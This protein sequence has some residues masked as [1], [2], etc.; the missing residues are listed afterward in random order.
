MSVPVQKLLA[1]QQ[2]IESGKLDQ[3]KA[4]LLRLAQGGGAQDRNL[5]NMLA[6]VLGKKGEYEQA[7]Y[8]LERALKA[9]PDDGFLLTNL[10]QLL[11]ETGKRAEAVEVLERAI[12][13]AP[14][15]DGAWVNLTSTL[16]AMRRYATAR[17]KAAEALE[18]FNGHARL[19]RNLSVAL[20]GAGE[21]QAAHEAARE[22]AT[23]EPSNPAA[24][25]MLAY[26]YN[27]VPGPTPA[28]ILAAHRA[29]G[30]CLQRLRPSPQAPAPTAADAERPLRVGMIGGDFCTHSV[31]FFVEPLLEHRD[32][33]AWHVTLY[34][35][36]TNTDATSERF[37]SLA[38]AWRHVAWMNERELIGQIQHDRIDVLID[39]AGHTANN[40][41]PILHLRAA[42]MQMTYCG[43]PATTGVAA[44]DYRIVDSLTDPGPQADAA[45]VEKLAR[46]DPCFLCYRPVQ[47]PSG[48][49]VPAPSPPPSASGA[50]VTFGSFN[51]LSKL[52]DRLIGV[53]RRVLDE[54]PGSRLLLKSVGLSEEEVRRDVAARFARAGIG[55]DRLELLASVPTLL[56]HLSLYARIDVALDNFPYHGTTTTCE[57][58]YM[59]VPV[60][61]LACEPGI[62][63]GR[64]G[65]SLLNAV[66]LPELVAHSEDEYVRLAADLARDRERLAAVRSG[67]RERLL[68]SPLCDGPGLAGRFWNLVRG[69][70]RERCGTTAA[71]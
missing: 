62:H 8:Y 63:A 68:R 42:P 16:I 65:V 67:L 45:A 35:T 25:S 49:R 69:C 58:L 11:S 19:L 5:V 37:I 39:L 10:G 41:L 21:P 7:R 6:F 33:S 9:S 60:V 47:A 34:H 18:R 44:V 20:L 38:D 52:N 17:A 64:V 48:E 15:L 31:A 30:E 46:L 40:R 1:A 71:G 66:G 14:G 29:Y 27:F 59:G 51:A 56:E 53:W 4:A 54:V 13:V 12:A 57:A 55:E 32:R 22:L 23:R 43:Y 70:W 26:T 36:A 61:T 50:P 2:L 24:L 28:Q 3:A